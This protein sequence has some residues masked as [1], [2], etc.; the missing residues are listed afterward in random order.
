MAIAPK[1][2]PTT[3]RVKISESLKHMN[4]NAAKKQTILEA[5]V[6]GWYRSE[7]EAIRLQLTP[8]SVKHKEG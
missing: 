4:K 2:D 6:S 8:I 5:R 7:S 1:A 3:K